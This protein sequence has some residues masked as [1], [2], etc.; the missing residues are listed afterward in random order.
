MRHLISFF[1]ILIFFTGCKSPE[2]KPKKESKSPKETVAAYLSATNRFDF[3]SAKEFLVPNK[4]N[5]IIIETLQKMEKS[6]PDN[7]KS[8]FINNEKDAV[9]YQKEITDSTAQIIVTPNQ[10]IVMPIKFNLKKMKDNW[11]IESV[12]LQ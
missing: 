4:E 3:K 5:L 12:I 10:D 6:I 11:L 9:Y 7:Q 1:A 8:R 2:E